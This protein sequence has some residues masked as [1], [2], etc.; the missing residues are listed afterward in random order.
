MSASVWKIRK[1]GTIAS[2]HARIGWQNLRTTEFLD[3]GDYYLITGTDFEDGHVNFDT[4]HY[5]EKKRFNQDANIQLQ[6]GSILI[7]KDGTLGKVAY[8]DKLNKPATLN[9]GVFNVVVK[10]E[11]TEKK[12]LF[13]LL[14]SPALMNYATIKS[15]GGTIKH[16][17]Q[18]VLIKFPVI[19]PK[20]IE[21]QKHIADILSTCDTV[22]QN[23]Q[24]T[25]DKHKAI[26]QGMM[27]DLFTRGL[28]KDGKLRP[29]YKEAPEL[30]K[31]SELG[32]IPK[33]WDISDFGDIGS[34]AMCKRVFQYET[35]D[36]G[37]IPFYKIG[38]FGANPDAYISKTLYESYRNLFSYPNKGDI[39]ISASG[40]IGRTVIFDGKPAY[41]QDSNI[42]WLAH[43]ERRILNNYLYYLYKT[44][45]WN[46][47]GSTIKRLY[48]DNFKKI[49]VSFPKDKL[50][51][52]EIAKRLSSIDL[53]IQKEDAILE[54]YKNIKT[55]LMA[56][57][58]TPPKDAVII[59][60]TEE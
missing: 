46:L 31:E 49:K 8:I 60:E 1:L 33:D 11:Q 37:E 18:N 6:I 12:Y 25:I 30:Y 23:T 7:T 52:D 36:E 32:I 39:L 53:A 51:Q 2:L 22:I 58:L 3:S 29:S 56:R 54:K 44:I 55:G 5:V 40:T 41:F 34:L 14:K 20:D 28:T 9:A 10:D 16:L 21:E 47:E 4:C 48:T 17:N 43:D 45:T 50:E 35:T 59:D 38:T 27:L 57:L 13:H 15:T 26:K 19:S 24:K 42:M